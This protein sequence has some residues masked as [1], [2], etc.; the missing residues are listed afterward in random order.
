MSI[1]INVYTDVVADGLQQRLCAWRAEH[2]FHMEI[3]VC[4]DCFS[5]PAQA[6]VVDEDNHDGL[7]LAVMRDSS[8]RA[9]KRLV[10][11]EVEET[12]FYI[13]LYE[14]DI[15]EELA[16]ELPEDASRLLGTI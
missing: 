14:P 11:E 7:L 2:A 10:P 12:R 16:H 13:G 9:R 5:T 15:E 1:N 4:L 6:G 3:D 8:T